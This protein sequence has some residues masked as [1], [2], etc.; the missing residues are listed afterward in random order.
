M[1]LRSSP[2][3]PNIPFILPTL[4]NKDLCLVNWSPMPLLMS[5]A[6]IIFAMLSK[7]TFSGVIYH[8]MGHGPLEDLDAQ[9][10][11][12]ARARVLSV[13]HKVAREIFTSMAMVFNQSL[14]SKRADLQSLIHI[15]SHGFELRERELKAKAM[16][17]PT[18]QNA[19]FPDGKEELL[20]EMREKERKER[21]EVRKY[22]R[23]WCQ[24]VGVTLR[25]D[26][27][28]SVAQTHPGNGPVPQAPLQT[29]IQQ[30]AQTQA[31]HRP[32]HQAQQQAQQQTLQRAHQQ[33]Y[34][35]TQ[36]HAQMQTLLQAYARHRQQARMQAQQP[37][38]QQAQQQPEQQ[39]QQQPQQDNNQSG[40]NMADT[41]PTNGPS[42]P[43][44]ALAA[45][46]ATSQRSSQG[47]NSTYTSSYQPQVPQ[48]Y[49]ALPAAPGDQHFIQLPEG[50]RTT[51]DIQPAPPPLPPYSRPCI[52]RAEEEKVT[53]F[54]R[55]WG[56]D[57]NL[58][59]QG[60]GPRPREPVPPLGEVWID[61]FMKPNLRGFRWL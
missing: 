9:Q 2:T 16:E 11:L 47:A 46:Q 15:W 50:H 43:P 25:M 54:L 41:P 55:T 35:H 29:V 17:S 20:S 19:R 26:N 51:P 61:G 59:N 60:H 6:H 57:G 10:T 4:L 39:P 13:Y 8:L 1:Y 14:E 36:Q 27:Q 21:A 45:S 24:D 28:D 33:A 37:N 18:W 53:S 12:Q 31:Q 22:F 42:V 5:T 58:W 44:L 3:T 40:T 23:Y 49:Q 52:T 38:Q 56:R 34:P 30:Q 7:N 32:Q 48:P